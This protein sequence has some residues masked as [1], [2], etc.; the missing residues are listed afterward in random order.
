MQNQP[1]ST[2][3][4]RESQREWK[5]C[6]IRN[7]KFKSNKICILVYLHMVSRSRS[8]VV[9]LFFIATMRA[10][11]A[12]GLARCDTF[13]YYYL[14]FLLVEEKKWFLFC[15]CDHFTRNLVCSSQSPAARKKKN[16]PT[17]AAAKHKI[18]NCIS[19]SVWMCAFSLYAWN[20]FIISFFYHNLIQMN[21]RSGWKCVY[22]IIYSALIW[23]S[24]E[25]ALHFSSEFAAIWNGKK[26]KLF[27]IHIEIGNVSQY[28]S[29]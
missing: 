19:C 25:K 26:T 28:I 11:K 9:F 29:L 3:S 14:L 5:T 23:R 27:E 4:G 24:K 20:F 13:L 1:N 12:I 18:R 16:Q 17:T 15:I 7:N 2:L 21:L 8:C 10:K 22:T 6:N